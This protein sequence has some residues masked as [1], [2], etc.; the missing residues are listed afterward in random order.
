[1]VGLTAVADIK[2]TIAT[3]G[4]SEETFEPRAPLTMQLYSGQA[5]GHQT[6]GTGNLSVTKPLV[7]TGAMLNSIGFQ[8][9]GGDVE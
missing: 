7:R 1:M 9:T 3:G 2:K 5:A 4:T 8:L 6:D